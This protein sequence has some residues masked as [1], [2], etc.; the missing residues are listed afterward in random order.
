MRRH[1]N[2]ECESCPLS[3]SSNAFV[4][5]K[6]PVKHY[7]NGFIIYQNEVKFAVVGE[8]PGFNEGIKGEPFVGPSGQLL[9]Q[10][11]DYHGIKRSEMVLTNACLCRP[12]GNATPDAT[13]IRCCSKRLRTDLVGVERVLALGNSAAKVLLDT[14]QGITTV[15]IGPARPSTLVKGLQVVPTVHPAACLR[16]GDMFPHLVNDTL[17]MIKDPE[18]WEPPQFV[19][20]DEPDLALLAIKELHEI[21]DKLYVDIECGIDKDNSFDH[22]NRY[23]LLC[24]GL[25]YAKRRV[26]VLGEN[27]CA[28]EEVRA[29][30]RGLLLSKK[31]AAHNGKFDLGGLYPIFGDLRLWFDTMLAHYC[32]DERPGIHRLEQL[33]VDRLGAPNWKHDIAK[34]LGPGKNYSHI[35]R[36]ILYKYNAYDVAV[37][38]DLMEDFI[39]E[40]E[41]HGLR[42]LHDFL[43]EAGNELKFLELNGITIDREYNDLLSTVYQTELDS[44]EEELNPIAEITK[45]DGYEKRGGGI[46]PRSPKQLKEL[47][48]DLNLKVRDT[49]ADTLQLV[50]EGLQ[51]VEARRT[52]NV[53][54]E[55]TA[56]FLTVL[57]K[58]RKKTKL[59]GT[60]V[61]GIRNRLYR[62]R[63]YTTYMLHSTTSGR[64]AS[65]NPNLQNIERSAEIRRQF[66][67]AHP[68]NVFVAGDYGQIEGRVICTLA[69][70]EYLRSIFQNKERDLFEELGFGLFGHYGL[71]KNE[72]VRVKAYFY[73]LG[74]GREAFSIA[75]EYRLP[76]DQTEKDIQAFMNLMPGVQKWQKKVKQQALNGEDLVTTF[77]RHRRFWLI[78]KENQKDVLNEALSFYPQS[79]ASDICLKALIRVRPALRGLGFLRMTIH[80]QLIAECHKDKKEEVATLMQ[81]IMLDE[82]QKW[83]D[84][85]PFTV[86]T[87][88]GTSWGDFEKAAIAE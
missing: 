37:G 75:Q 10:V 7:G 65:R 4:P 42:D 54:E 81:N 50:L 34:Y 41:R 70:D 31:L 40:L 11:L 33:G 27:A 39:G 49:R 55:R 2:A 57:L 36:P 61:K 53:K 60:Y 76:L 68:D 23:D 47:F 5:T 25:G 71:T 80:D 72:R 87:E 26:A 64:L 74:Y 30:L 20:L 52:L 86:D 46:N 85:V 63:V 15:R 62:G 77:G 35:P 21:T 29:A 28:D 17:K 6:R 16:S 83:T 66:V 8:A 88:Y 45:P 78:T 12:S 59:H 44:L 38:W 1:P 13:A 51:R 14:Q 22:P 19:V 67:V 58:H 48:A 82:A 84:Y 73:G 69:Q 24:V 79:T 9:N 3:D 43:V 56:E 18:P 32:L